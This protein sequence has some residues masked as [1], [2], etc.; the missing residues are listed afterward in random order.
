MSVQERRDRDVK[1]VEGK[2]SSPEMSH[3]SMLRTNT[4]GVVNFPFGQNMQRVGHKCQPICHASRRATLRISCGITRRNYQGHTYAHLHSQLYDEIKPG[5]Q[6]TR[7]IMVEEGIGF[8]TA[9]R[10][11]QAITSE[12]Y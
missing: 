2:I 11:Y 6:K 10:L 1:I 4:R 7:R 5:Y 3:T 8:R 12:V 9:I